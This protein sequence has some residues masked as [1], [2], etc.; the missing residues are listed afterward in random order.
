MAKKKV[1]EEYIPA[2]EINEL[3]EE[4]VLIKDDDDFIA[5]KLK[6][7]NEMTDK[8]KARRLAERVLSN[9]RR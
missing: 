4:A 2:E 9:K 1:D 5:R 6:A 7:I 8:A 3:H